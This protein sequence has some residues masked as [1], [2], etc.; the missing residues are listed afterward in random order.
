MA[1]YALVIAVVNER[2]YDIGRDISRMLCDS[3]EAHLTEGNFVR[4]RCM[5]RFFG[6]LAMVN[7]ISTSSFLGLLDELTLC[8]EGASAEGE[9]ITS[10]PVR[11]NDFFAFSALGL[12]PWF[13]QFLD[14]GHAQELERIMGIIE[15]YVNGRPSFPVELSIFTG[16][17]NSP[18]VRVSGAFI[19]PRISFVQ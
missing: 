1:V 14:A 19:V 5:L 10:T 2:N 11:R 9:S 6:E 17:D 16:P 4:F 13:G 8:L 3:L 12:L 7:F 15:T 18:D